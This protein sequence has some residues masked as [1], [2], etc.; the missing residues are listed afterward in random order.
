M[1][2]KIGND[3]LLLNPCNI[4]T[5]VTFVTFVTLRPE[6]SSHLC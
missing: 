1:I 5:T 6:A 4:E 3:F 2:Q